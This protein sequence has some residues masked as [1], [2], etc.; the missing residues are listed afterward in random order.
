[1]GLG[2]AI[3]AFQ[4]AAPAAGAAMAVAKKLTAKTAKTV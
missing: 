4:R 1:M 2:F 3:N